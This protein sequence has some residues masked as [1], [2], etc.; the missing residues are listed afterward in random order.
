MS[1]QVKLNLFEL[2]WDIEVSTIYTTDNG[3]FAS[4][5]VN[6]CTQVA[7]PATQMTH[8]C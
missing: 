6:P 5:T 7:C 8:C 1:N 3:G 4:A 2:N